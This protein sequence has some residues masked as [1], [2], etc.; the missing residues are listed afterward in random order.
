[1]V[2]QEISTAV[3]Q[4]VRII[5]RL[6]AVATGMGR[7][8]TSTLSTL[9][10]LLMLGAIA[11]RLHIGKSAEKER[12]NRQRKVAQRRQRL[13]WAEHTGLISPEETATTLE[14]ALCPATFSAS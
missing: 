1:M 14:E 2:W 6:L 10:A 9:I 13:A 5:L 12:H 3:A 4:V 11:W 8:S 7:E